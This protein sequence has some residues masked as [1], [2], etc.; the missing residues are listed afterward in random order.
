MMVRPAGIP[1]AGCVGFAERIGFAGLLA[2]A[3]RKGEADR[4]S[5]GAH[6]FCQVDR[7]ALVLPGC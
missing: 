2:A 4:N 6:W 5:C 3:S 7:R 1:L